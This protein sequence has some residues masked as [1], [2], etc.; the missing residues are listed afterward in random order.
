MEN[1]FLYLV[2]FKHSSVALYN[3]AHVLYLTQ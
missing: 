2:I 3:I 1:F